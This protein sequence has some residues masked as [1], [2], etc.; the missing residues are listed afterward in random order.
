MGVSLGSLW[1]GGHVWVVYRR[2]RRQMRA[3]PILHASSQLRLPLLC[4][5]YATQTSE[6]ACR[7]ERFLFECRKVIGFALSAPYDWLKTLAPLFHPIGNK[8]ET[9]CDV[10]ACIFPRFASATC[11]YFE[12]WLVHCIVCVLCDW[13]EQLLWFWFYDTQLKTTLFA[14]SK[15]SD[16]NNEATVTSVRQDQAFFV[17]KIWRELMSLRPARKFKEER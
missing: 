5:R 9:T 8:T 2:Q 1:A 3:G 13:L 15:T 12:F 7:L 11:Y 10:F 17:S 14:G 6:P 4:P 16:R